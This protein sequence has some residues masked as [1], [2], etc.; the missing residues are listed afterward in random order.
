MAGTKSSEG[1]IIGGKRNCG[2]TTELIKKACMEDLYILCANKHMA[3]LIFQQAK[4]MN[5]VI[6]YPITI[7]DLPLR[8][9][10]VK[11]ILVDEVGAVL[12]SLIGERIVGMSSSMGFKE[13]ESLNNDKHSEK[14]NFASED[15][16]VLECIKC[17]NEQIFRRYDYRQDG[18]SCSNCEGPVV[19]KEY[20]D[21]HVATEEAFNVRDEIID[22]D[23]KY[24][25]KLT[26]KQVDTIIGLYNEVKQSGA[27]S[28]SAGTFKL[29]IDCVDALKGLKSI[30]REAKK[31]TAA[32]KE[33]DSVEENRCPKC[34]RLSVTT[35]TMTSDLMG[36]HKKQC[37]KCGWCNSDYT[38]MNGFA[39]LGDG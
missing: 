18:I 37:R 13:L 33:L 30:Q 12:S 8:G 38:H 11:G 23:I 39:I 20:Q 1:K 2:K 9:R 34:E 16:I 6:P 4:E 26:P 25:R 3:N 36:V 7:D 29:D 27:S 35:E 32:L 21:R 24:C 19:K 17:G 10:S 14:K 28:A 22:R 31:A 5:Y 15:K